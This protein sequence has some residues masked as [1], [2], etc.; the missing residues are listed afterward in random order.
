VTKSTRGRQVQQLEGVSVKQCPP[1]A[2][3][4]FKRPDHLR[5]LAHTLEACEGFRE[6]PVT[7][8][9]DGPRRDADRSGVEAVT[10]VAAELG[11]ENLT[12]VKASSNL[13]LRR[14]IHKGV[15]SLLEGATSVI[16]L[17]D[18]LLLA[19]CAL[20]YFRRSLEV[21]ADTPAVFAVSGYAYPVPEFANRQSAMLLPV[22]TSWGWATWRRVWQHFEPNKENFAHLN[23]SAAFRRMF[24]SPG[25]ISA[26]AMLDLQMRGKIDSWAILWNAHLTR[27]R[28]L[29]VFPPRSVIKNGGLTGQGATHSSGLN[30]PSRLRSRLEIEAP[31]LKD[32]ENLQLPQVVEIDFAAL[33][34]IRRSRSNRLGRLSSN[35]GSIR[36][37]LFFWK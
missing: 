28:G 26:N 7:I 16:V 17:E 15:S 3:F 19:P 32:V 10:K 21:Y 33:D 35:L 5:R 2:I 37:Q 8:F 6:H 1:I 29:S 11:W 27:R 20:E 9:I 12:I 30:L 36:R 4:A 31:Y 24:G 34:S 13:G 25:I 22:A 14:S 18:D 23:D